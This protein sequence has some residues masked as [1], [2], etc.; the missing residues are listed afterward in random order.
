MAPIYP[1]NRHVKQKKLVDLINVAI[2]D[3]I[4]QVQDIVPEKLRQEYRLLKDQV[5][6]EKMHHPK[7][8]HEAELAKRSAIFREFFYF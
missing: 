3:F 8:S 7:N 1:V 6:I 5:I 2:D 4:D